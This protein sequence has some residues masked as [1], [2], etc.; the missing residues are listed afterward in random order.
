MPMDMPKDTEKYSAWL[1]ID[2]GAI[3]NNVNKL[4]Q[5]SGKPVMAIVK[6]NGYGHG[7]LES[8][9]AAVKGGATWCGVARVEE[10]IALREAG[11]TC[12]ILV[13]GFTPA[14][15]V[16]EAI[17]HG[18]TLTVYDPQVAKEYAQKARNARKKL[19]LHVK[20]DSGM[21]RLGLFPEDG[22]PFMRWLND[23][24]EFT[25][26]GVFSHFARADEPD[27][28]TTSWQIERFNSLVR[29]LESEGIRPP[30]VH[31]SNSAGILYHPDGRFDLV[32]SGIA[33]YGLDPSS[34]APLPHGFIPALSLKA[35]LTSV[36]E[37]PAKHGVGYNYYYVTDAPER[38]GVVS[39]GYADGFRRRKGSMT[40]IHGKR[41]PVVGMVCMD[42]CMVSL[43]DLPEARIGDEVVLIG[44]QGDQHLS[45][46]EVAKD[47]GTINYEVA[48]GM[49]N[50]LPRLYFDS[51]P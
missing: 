14:D 46:E 32:R 19:C 20:F 41:T 39:I 43:K 29:A 18:L 37:L 11:L 22:L 7:M 42:Q 33:I 36:K 40:L 27:L 25:V 26:E 4:I 3:R 31:S 50:R 1:E 8:A 17:Q 15:Q 5:I 47:W 2:L 44:R 51:L 21:G 30:L 24:P 12:N 13:M 49:A 23:Q 10:G 45:M 16:I 6:A 28:E 48:T 38:V 35:R 9:L 34:Q